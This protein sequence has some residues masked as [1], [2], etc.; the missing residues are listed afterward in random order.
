MGN[1]LRRPSSSDDWG[2]SAAGDGFSDTEAGEKGLVRN[3]KKGGFITGTASATPCQEV[4]VKIRKK[5]L[6]EL[7]GRADVKELSVQQVLAQL[8]HATSSSS[9]Q[10]DEANQRSWRPTLQSIPE[11]I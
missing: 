6:E 2:T 11:L 9:N 10:Y 5:Q 1:C 7:L 8:I 3:H 4:K